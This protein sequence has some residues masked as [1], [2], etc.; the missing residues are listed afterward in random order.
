[1]S[2]Q[3]FFYDGQIRRF[4][5]QFIRI[6]SNFQ[7]Q[8]GRDV[9]GNNTLVQVPVYYG[10]ASRQ[11][12]AILR[13]NSE[14]ALNTVPA[15]SV[16]MS[17][18]SYDRPRMQEPNFVD[19]LHVRQRAVDPQTGEYLTTQGNTFTIERLMPVPYK[20]TMK[21]DIWTSNTE[22]KLQILEQLAIFFNPAMEIQSTDNY[23]DWGSL[24]YVELTDINLTSRTIPIGT[25]NPIDIG[26]M[27][28]EMPIWISPP[29]KVKKLGVI[30]KIITSIY[31]SN[32]DISESIYNDSLM[33][34]SRLRITLLNYGILVGDGVIQLLK[35]QDTISPQDPSSLDI[36]SKVGTPSS[37]RELINVYGALT[38]GISEIKLLLGDEVTEVVGTVS[39]HPSNETLLLYGVDEDTLPVNNLDAINSVIDPQQT[40]PG[41]GLPSPASGQRYLLTRSI[42][43]FENSDPS[44]AWGNL[45]AN[46]NDII[47]FVN[48]SWAVVFESV[49][50]PTD[51]Y[52]L[53]Q[54]SNVQ[55]HWNG[56]SWGRSYQGEYKGG[57]WTLV[58]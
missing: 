35:L 33:M 31:D 17:A 7:V 43:D 49:Q 45:V 25:E 26:T 4:V 19:K 21:A 10:D 41:Y 22:Q 46:S 28:F 14:N 16:Y 36:P 55:L 48:T 23:V 52:L 3:T 53:N 38:N 24:S 1:M 9:N 40:A 44:S 37:W 13:Q 39:Y 6:L 32:G 42:G 56:S 54:A 51:K 34:G 50:E 8:Y 27:T 20:L 18:L 57:F 2:L 58:L 29:A 15:I 11:A 5:S 30:Q 12:Q 47:E